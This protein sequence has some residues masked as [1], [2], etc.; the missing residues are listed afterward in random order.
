MSSRNVLNII[1]GYTKPFQRRIDNEFV[2]HPCRINYKI[3]N[4]RYLTF[5]PKI[6]VYRCA[7]FD[8][9]S[10][11]KSKE[12]LHYKMWFTRQV[13]AGKCMIWFNFCFR[14]LPFINT[15]ILARLIRKVRFYSFNVTCMEL[16]KSKTEQLF[17]ENSEKQESSIN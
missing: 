9:E 3:Q 15:K 10:I 1:N 12:A 6:N 5:S 11:I 16:V 2:V 14:V 4:W 17:F 8:N 7:F 13:F